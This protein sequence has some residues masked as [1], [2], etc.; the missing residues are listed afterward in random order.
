MVVPAESKVETVV[1]TAATEA[2]Q[3]VR[4][5]A[6]P[7]SVSRERKGFFTVRP[8]RASRYLVAKSRT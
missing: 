2:W 5:A 8:D 4:A 6:M 3:P 7:V 1:G